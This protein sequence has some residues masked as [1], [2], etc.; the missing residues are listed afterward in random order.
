MQPDGVPDARRQAEAAFYDPK[1]L[2]LLYFPE[3]EKYG[4]PS[5]LFWTVFQF[6]R[7]LCHT[8]LGLRCFILFFLQQDPCLLD[9]DRGSQSDV[10]ADSH[11]NLLSFFASS[12]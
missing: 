7:S 3:D 6:L 1:M 2:A 10:A 9:F 11:L 4:I 5:T 8:T 12:S